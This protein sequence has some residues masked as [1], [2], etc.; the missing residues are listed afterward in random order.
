M[1]LRMNKKF[2]YIFLLLFFIGSNLYPIFDYD[3]A[4]YAGQQEKW[5]VAAA[6]LTSLVIDHSDNPSVLYDAG[7]ASYKREEYD[8]ARAYFEGAV[9]NKDISVGLKEQAYFNAGNAAVQQKKLHDAVHS[10]EQVLV[11]NKDNERARHNLELVKKMLEEEKQKQDKQDKRDKKDKQE[12]D[13]DKENKDKQD[14]QDKQEQG[15]EKQEKE[16]KQDKQQENRD[17]KEK[18]KQGQ[19]K[20]QKQEKQ[21]QDKKQDQQGEQ[22]KQEKND[23]QNKNNQGQEKKQKQEKDGQGEQEKQPGEKD[24]KQAEKQEVGNLDAN[25]KSFDK[26]DAW[27]AKVL[28]QREQD[29][30]ALNKQMIKAVVEQELAGQDGQNCW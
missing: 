12:E 7:V 28:Q 20:K 14:K 5:D 2:I 22:D 27:L 15:Q 16:D 4:I 25:Q 11:L 9:A 26:V 23:Q 8:H 19:D 18:N 24:G 17:K 21:E 13:K 29:D 6:G 10:Y 30:A 3:R 1:K